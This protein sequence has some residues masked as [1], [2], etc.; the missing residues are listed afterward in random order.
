MPK[1]KNDFHH[2]FHGVSSAEAGAFI[3][4]RRLELGF[5]QIPFA[6]LI[7]MNA[8]ARMTAF[9]RGYA[10]WRTSKYAADILEHLKISKSEALEHLGIRILI[11]YREPE[12]PL[13]TRRQSR[14]Q[15]G[16]S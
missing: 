15:H 14:A 1:P 7:G 6:G 13:P 9:E 8:T 11:D 4:A 3:R 16:S 2:L 12:L 5:D 10:D